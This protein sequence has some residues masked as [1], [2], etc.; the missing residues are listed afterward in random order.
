MSAAIRF[1]DMSLHRRGALS[2]A[3][4][5]LTGG[6]LGFAGGGGESGVNVDVRSFDPIT[7]LDG[8]VVERQRAVAADAIENGG[9]RLT[10]YAS[11]PFRDPTLVPHDGAVYRVRGEQVDTTDVTAFELSAEWQAGQTPTDAGA[12]P[13]AELPANDRRAFR[14]AVPDR[15]EAGAPIKQFTVRNHSVPYPAGGDGS[16]LIGNTTWVEWDDRVVRVEIPGDRTR[17]I[18]R[19][20]YEFTAEHVADGEAAF[21]SYLAD[22]FLVDFGDAPEAQLEILRAAS[23]DDVYDECDPQPDALV[24]LRDRLADEP[25]LP[26]PYPDDWYVAFDGER[27]RLSA[28]TWTDQPLFAPST[29][30][31]T[32]STPS[33]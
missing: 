19:S 1:P 6:C 30:S 31:A 11:S 20:T 12:V 4:S 23:G 33:S 18:G 16:V 2:I 10:T 5:L 8:R 28:R 9:T 15:P 21:R 24:A 14:M 13:F 7:E 3:A 29:V 25:T 32:A 22:A 17:T 26:E 27:S